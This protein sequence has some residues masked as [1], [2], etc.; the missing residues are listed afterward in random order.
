MCACHLCTC[1][2]KT[3]FFHVPLWHLISMK[4]FTKIN[5]FGLLWQ[6]HNQ[7]AH[8]TEAHSLCVIINSISY[9]VICDTVYRF[10]HGILYF[11]NV[12]WFCDTCITVILCGAMRNVL[13]PCTSILENLQTWNCLICRSPLHSFI[14]L[15]YTL[16]NDWL[17]DWLIYIGLEPLW[18][19]R[20]KILS[21]GS[22]R[23]TQMY[24]WCVQALLCVSS[25]LTLF[26]NICW[27][28]QKRS[29][30]PKWKKT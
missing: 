2:G 9:G 25:Y 23:W 5:F 6:C 11:Q 12:L 16:E 17:M 14:Q 13:L 24:S 4:M 30:P 29:P 21:S 10:G 20:L 3:P 7:T 19:C 18:A 15:A 22:K 8:H 27:S 1:S 28:L 26:I